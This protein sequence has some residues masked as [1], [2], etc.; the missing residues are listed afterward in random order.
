MNHMSALSRWPGLRN[1]T[2]IH[3]SITEIIKWKALTLG[4]CCMLD[5]ILGMAN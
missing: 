3:L 1:E 5:G 2:R 4:A